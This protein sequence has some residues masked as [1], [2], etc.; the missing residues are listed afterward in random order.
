[1]NAADAR[2]ADRPGLPGLLAW[3]AGLLLAVAAAAWLAAVLLVD[4][5]LVEDRLSDHLRSY[6][7]PHRVS[8]AD[9]AVLPFRRGLGIDSL[10]IR[11]TPD[12]SAPDGAVDGSGAP[13]GPAP[14]VRVARVVVADV[15]LAALVGGRL[16]PG[17]VRVTGARLDLAGGRRLEIEDLE[18]AVGAGRATLAGAELFGAGRATTVTDGDTLVSADTTKLTLAG[19]T[20]RGLDVDTSAGGPAATARS[21]TVDRPE[22]TVVDAVFP[23][24]DTAPPGDRPVT[25]AR[26]LRSAPF[27]GHIDSVTLRNGRITYRERRPAYPAAGEISFD[28]IGG[29]V[30]PL[31]VGRA[32]SADA[33]STEVALQARING[34]AP[35]WLTV[36]FPGGDDDFGFDADAVAVDL[37]LATLNSM[38]RPVS[39]IHLRGGRLDSLAFHLHVRN[40]RGNGEVVALYEGL[41]LALEDPSGGGGGLVQE[42]REFV[43]GI[44]LNEDNLRSEEDYRTGE[45]RNHEAERG[46]T[47]FQYLWKSLLAG[48]RD[49]ASV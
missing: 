22:L 28:D 4:A 45:V 46:E 23:R 21:M 2:G 20:I 8:V 31:R 3:A 18:L 49:V 19:L 33:D 24:P 42:V 36:R 5:E 26:R 30:R 34:S 29:T 16:D 11:T 25:P 10:V 40:G 9:V 7:G 37:D 15:G 48:L 43:M 1:M 35:L 14:R 32:A 38:F 12:R 44:S 27:R 39:G 13:P 47:F 6:L 41:E 17:R